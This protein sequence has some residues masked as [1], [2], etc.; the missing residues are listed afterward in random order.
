MTR[1]RMEQDKYTYVQAGDHSIE[2]Y[3]SLILW[4]MIRE[5]IWPMTKVSTNDLETQLAELS[6]TDCNTSV[7]TLITKMLDIKRQIEA[8]KGNI[9]DTNHF[10]TL[11]F[12]MLSNYN[13][14]MFCY[15]FISSCSN[16]NKEAMTMQE[17]FE[18][19]KTVYKSEQAAGTWSDLMP[20]KL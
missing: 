7:P 8:E 10:M 14:G 20:T 9:Y 15:E 18:A 12:T 11:F 4:A 2:H 3:C 13:N 5:E 6:F 17:V 16:Y 1:F 19:L